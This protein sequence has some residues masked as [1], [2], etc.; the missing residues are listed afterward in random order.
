[1]MEQWMAE[2]PTWLLWATIV[3]GVGLLTVGADRAIAGASRLAAVLGMSPVI[4]GATVV[5]LGTTAPEAIVSVAAALKGQGGLALGNGVGSVICDTALIFGLSCCLARLPIDRYVLR[6]HGWLQLGAGVL[7]AVTLGLLALLAGGIEGVVMPRA[8]GLVFVALLFAYLAVSVKWARGHPESF[9]KPPLQPDARNPWLQAGLDTLLC[10]FGLA[11]VVGG[12]EVLI[13][14]V[15]EVC[16]RLKVPADILAVTV[17]AFGTSLPE[18]ATAMAAI[19]KGHTELLVGNVVGAD[20]LNVLFV[21][22]ASAA[23][24]PLRVPATFYYAHVPVMLAALIMLRIWIATGMKKR[25]FSRWQGVPL[26][27]LYAGYIVVLVHLPNP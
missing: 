18:A 11:L 13:G 12:S 5:S 25:R 9:E 16:T 21:I 1:M 2:S 3:F 6:R 27:L 8:V 4:I 14:A 26:L 22:G 19:I 23:A 24:V 17:V 10:F 20:I 7:L 15:T